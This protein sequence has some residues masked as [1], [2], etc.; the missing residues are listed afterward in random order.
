MWQPDLESRP[1]FVHLGT[2]VAPRLNHDWP[3]TGQTVWGGRAADSA[4]GISWDWIEVTAGVVAIADPM[5]MITNLRVIGREGEV[6]TAYE[7]APHLNG[8]VHGLA[9]QAEV[10]RALAASESEER[11]RASVAVAP[12]RRLGSRGDGSRN[13]GFTPLT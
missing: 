7:A 8:I 11:R 13:S 9:W 1:H 4:A 2:H 12:T 6:L 10:Q 3:C 5:M